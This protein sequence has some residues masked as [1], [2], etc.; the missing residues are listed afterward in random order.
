[1]TRSQSMKAALALASAIV[2]PLLDAANFTPATTNSPS[3]LLNLSIAYAL[4][5][6]A[7]K[8]LA[9]YLMYRF[10]IKPKDNSYDVPQEN[11]PDRSSHH[12]Q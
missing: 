2:F 11:N 5:P 9:A 8:L 7:I 3:A 12:A 1:M 6:C 10:F 4:I